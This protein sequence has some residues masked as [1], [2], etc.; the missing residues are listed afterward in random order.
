MI[1]FVDDEPREMSSYVEELRFSGYEVAYESDVDSALK[2]FAANLDNLDLVILDI[3]MPPGEALKNRDTEFGLRTG[4]YMYREF[5]V[6][7]PDLP[8][9]ILTNVSDVQ[10]ARFF[11]QEAKCI[12][13]P[14]EDVLPYELAE[15][16]AA[17]LV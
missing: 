16:V 10:V 6:Q 2:F 1:L 17:V 12:F 11:H 8:V 9:I 14:K 7:S 5:R 13:L 4:I 3:M 15:Q